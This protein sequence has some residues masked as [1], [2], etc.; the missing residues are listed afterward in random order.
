MLDNLGFA[1]TFDPKDLTI[2][3]DILRK[4]QSFPPNIWNF[5]ETEIKK[6][7]RNQAKHI[8]KHRVS[9][10]T[11]DWRRRMRNAKLR[12]ETHKGSYKVPLYGSQVGRRT[13]TFLGDLRESKEPGVTIA[14]GGMG[15]YGIA[16][17]TF[18]YSINADAF[19]KISGWGGYPNKFFDYLQQ[20]GI[21]SEEGF[22]AM[23]DAEEELLLDYLEKEIEASL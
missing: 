23:G 5:V 20:R 12:V 22:L 11:R 2:G 18:E 19:A 21:I 3:R 10:S 8:A 9:E 15:H 16:N 1:V 7:A 13:G 17:G 14:K 4:L 6:F